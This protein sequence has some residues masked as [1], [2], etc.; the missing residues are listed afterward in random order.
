APWPPVRLFYVVL[1]TLARERALYDFT[2][3][4]ATTGIV[5]DVSFCCGSRY[6]TTF[7]SFSRS[8]P[9]TVRART[10]SLSGPTSIVA[11]GFASRL[12]YQAGFAAAPLSDAITTKMLPD[13][14]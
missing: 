4:S 9:L 10:L 8:L 3:S 5:R 1:G 13:L 11:F 12:T 6:S 14:R 2:F 7:T